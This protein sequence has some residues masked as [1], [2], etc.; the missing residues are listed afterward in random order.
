MADDGAALQL[1]RKLM[2][3]IVSQ[4]IVAVT[5][6]G[7]PDRIADGP[8][9]VTDLACAVGADPVA[10][11]RFLRALAA[12]GVFTEDE[13]GRFGLTA[14]GML[15]RTESPGSLRHFARLMTGEAYRAW[16]DAEYSVRTGLPAFER[17]F[18]MPM[19][20]WLADHD[21][22]SVRFNAAQAGLAEVRMSPLL[23]RD[24]SGTSTV[25]DV[26]GGN[27]ALLSG[28]LNA[29]PHLRGILFDLPH[30]AGEAERKLAAA[31]LSDR[32]RC[33]GGD[34]RDGVP[35]GGDVYVLAQI[36]HD[37]DD[38]TAVE[39]LRQCRRALPAQGRLLILEL[40]VPENDVPHPAKLLDLHM[41]VML[42][43]RERTLTEWRRLLADSHLEVTG[44]V[45]HTRSSMI[46]AQI[47]PQTAPARSQML[48]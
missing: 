5:E 33:V 31:G 12:E 28:L 41:M 36:L 11:R 13:H 30:V 39:I 4:A 17:V 38:T 26:G 42:G 14:M 29:H 18:G 16:S 44:T 21:R 34:F 23:D 20:E 37:W 45:D 25:V 40:I 35:A 43:G 10:L 2:G 7:V 22:A 24:W 9:D 32:V 3:F 19:F 46:E 8:A 15:L 6:L 48:V 27:G 1:R 47:S